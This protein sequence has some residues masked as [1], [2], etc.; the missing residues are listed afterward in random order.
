MAEESRLSKPWAP[1][2]P[3]LREEAFSINLL[4]SVSEG[5]GVFNNRDLEAP[6]I[7]L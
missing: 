7:L 4:G 6:G 1:C 5:H 2:K 3:V